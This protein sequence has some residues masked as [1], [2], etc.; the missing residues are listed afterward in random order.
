M[1]TGILLASFGAGNLQSSA[2]LKKVQA[3]VEEKFGLPVRWAYTSETMR[4]RLASHA[5]TKSDS[6]SKALLRMRFDRYERV[7]VQS[8][9]LIPGLE[10]ADLRAEAALAVEE[11]GLEV[12]VGRPLLAEPGD[13]EKAALALL[14]HLPADRGP[15]DAVVC[16][17]HGSLHES[18]T[19]YLDWAERVK[20]ADTGVFVACMKGS[21]T[22]DHIL[23]E[24]LDRAPSR[25]WLLPLL[26]VV[27]RHT[28]DDMAGN[29]PESWK[30]RLERAGFDCRAD[31]K[32]LADGPGF[33]ALWLERLRQTLSVCS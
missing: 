17:G 29:R 32:G 23:P 24:L 25:I 2:T 30:N 16:M 26:S 20:R 33:V 22:L 21:L 28:L 7:I 19:L 14:D 31:L 11:C 27:G 15:D 13:V 1:K 5:H 12:R 4:Q 9:H 3:E 8:L 18:E 6:V 10:Y